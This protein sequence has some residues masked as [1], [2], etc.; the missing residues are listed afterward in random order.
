LW[1]GSHRQVSTLNVRLVSLCLLLLFVS[2]CL[3]LLLLFLLLYIIIKIR[4]FIKFSE[5][6]AALHTRKAPI[7]VF[8]P[9]V[10]DPQF[11]GQVSY[12][13]E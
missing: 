6:Q 13:E 10:Q 3:L 5:C 1:N 12:H 7:D 11:V 4:V 9:T 2:L 8:L